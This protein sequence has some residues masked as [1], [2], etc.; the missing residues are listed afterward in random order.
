MLDDL[1]ESV[2][3][4]PGRVLGIGLALGAGILI[5]RGMRPVA[6]GA[7]KGYLSVADRVREFGA[8]AGESLEDLYH[9]ARAERSEDLTE[10]EA[11]P[12]EPAPSEPARR[13]GRSRQP[14]SAGEGPAEA[15]TPE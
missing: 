13:R 10:E 15:A 9:E 7:I 12:S 4:F 2:G 5:G 8:E 6:K 3:G 11:A 14:R 1:L